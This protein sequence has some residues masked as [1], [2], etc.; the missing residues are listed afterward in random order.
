M[1]NGLK[2]EN[3]GDHGECSI[4]FFWGMPQ[5]DVD[6]IKRNAKKFGITVEDVPPTRMM[7]AKLE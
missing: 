1:A 5:Q 2:I 4:S 6:L 7:S 3:T